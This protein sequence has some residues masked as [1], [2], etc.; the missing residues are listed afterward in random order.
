[1]STSLE[2]NE[3]DSLYK[4]VT[5]PL[6]KSLFIFNP[7]S[8]K[9]QI[10]FDLIEILQILSNDA[11]VITCYPTK[12][13]GDARNVVRSR[14][15]DYQYVFCAGG[16]GTLDEVVTGMMESRDKKAVPIGYIPAGTTN[17]F[18][19]SLGIPSDMK[20]AARVAARGKNFKCDLGRINGDTYFTYVAAFGVFTET[21]YETPQ[22]MKNLLGHMAY[23]LQGVMDLG[24]LRTYHFSVES[25]ELSISDEFVF[26][27]ITNSK[28]V[29]GI[30]DITGSQVDMSDGLF[31]VTLIKMP[32]N[33]L[34]LGEIV[35][36]LSNA[37]DTSDFVYQFKTSHIVM[38]SPEMVKWTKDGEYGGS[39]KRVEITNL[40][41]A[42]E[43]IVPRDR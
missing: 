31:E 21:S 8:G 22:D 41:K 42:F 26:G 2:N 7:V 33:I 35:Q 32:T 16:D 30:P 11:Y 20:A 27:M 18:A 10:R 3:R 43:I 29:G 23:V 36:Y 19:S 37:I 38:E 13:Q 12:C 5:E 9:S 40:H 34:E 1:M 39:Y 25:D 17:D 24:K 14:R 15:D 28:S 4:A 6:K